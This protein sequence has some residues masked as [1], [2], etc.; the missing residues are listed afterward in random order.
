MNDSQRKI[1]FWL[2]LLLSSPVSWMFSD[3]FREPVV[4]VAF[5][6]AIVGLAFYVRAG[7][8]K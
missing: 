7:G 6:I 2:L 3:G 4:F 1:L 8:K 5:T